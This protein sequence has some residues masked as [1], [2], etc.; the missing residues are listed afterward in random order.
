MPYDN[1]CYWITRYLN[2]YSYSSFRWLISFVPNCH[3]LWLWYVQTTT[4][5]S[6][7]TVSNLIV[8]AVLAAVILK[9]IREE[10]VEHVVDGFKQSANVTLWVLLQTFFKKNSF[11]KIHIDYVCTQVLLKVIDSVSSIR[12]HFNNFGVI[13]YHKIYFTDERAVHLVF[14]LHNKSSFPITF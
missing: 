7:Y 8:V 5:T 4:N 6:W 3:W 10:I 11:F 9:Y 1:A 14:A 2:I 12:N 13:I